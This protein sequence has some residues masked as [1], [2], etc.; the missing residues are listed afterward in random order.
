M[1]FTTYRLPDGRLVPVDAS[2]AKG[3]LIIGFT[4]VGG[5]VVDAVR[6]DAVPPRYVSICSWCQMTPPPQAHVIY[7]HIVCADCQARIEREG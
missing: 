5:R 2:A 4:L 7:T 1:D 6:A 3:Q